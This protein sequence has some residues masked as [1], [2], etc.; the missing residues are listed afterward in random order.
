MYPNIETDM[1]D[2]MEKKIV[3]FKKK[4]PENTDTTLKLAK[5]RAIELGI[6]HVVVASTSGETGK[7]A[8]EVFKDVEISVVV[9]T[10]QAGYKKEGQLEIK[11]EYRRIIE[12]NGELVIASDLFTTVPKIAQ[13]YANPFNLIADVLRLFS[14]GVKVCVECTVMAADAGA[15]PVDKETIAIAGTVR[16]AD[17]ALVLKPA[18]VHR[19]FDLDIREIVAI[20]REK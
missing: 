6:E 15:I 12:E 9:V 11:N 20:P 3:Y 2:K 4:G 5:E 19:F 18:N 10:H 17:T 8:I 1:G 7:R 14:Q 13:K 16:G